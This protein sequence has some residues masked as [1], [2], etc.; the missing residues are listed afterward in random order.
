MNDCN[1]QLLGCRALRSLTIILVLQWSQNLPCWKA[2][3][4]CRR[5]T[6]P[7]AVL[8]LHQN[9]WPWAK[10]RWK[11]GDFEKQKHVNQGF[12]FGNWSAMVT[13]LGQK[14]KSADIHLFIHHLC[15]KQISIF[16]SGGYITTDPFKFAIKDTFWKSGQSNRAAC[17]YSS[18][19][20][21]AAC[22][23]CKKSCFPCTLSQL[24]IP[25]KNSSPVPC[26]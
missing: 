20:C 24:M 10:R 8:L 12:F 5:F 2:S 9:Y 7:A 11:Q 13:G 25:G 3:G 4:L 18:A 19:G 15:P 16:Y 14:P 22:V 21:G 6:N 1:L 26:Y 23:F 17:A